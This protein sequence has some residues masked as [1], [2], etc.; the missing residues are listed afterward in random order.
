MIF[1]IYLSLDDDLIRDEGPWAM[2]L[3][4]LALVLG[5]AGGCHLAMR[6][7]QAL[8]SRRAERARANLARQERLRERQLAL[9]GRL[10]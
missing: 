8:Q 9:S 5:G 2:T 3:A 1:F 4:R 7:L 6:A 10:E